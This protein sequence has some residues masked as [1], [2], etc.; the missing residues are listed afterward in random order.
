MKKVMI[1]D[2]NEDVLEMVSELVASNGYQPITASGGEDC[3]LKLEKERP[4]LILLDIN[5]PDIDGWSVLRKLKEMGLTDS[6]KVMMLT[7]TTDVG[8]DIFGLQDVV[9][10]YIRKPFSNRDLSERLGSALDDESMKVPEQQIVAVKEKK[11]GFLSRILGKSRNDELT[12][13]GKERVDASAMKYTVR[14]GFGYVVKEKKPTRSFEIFVDQVTHEIQGLCVTRQHPGTIRTKW[15]LEKTP[16]IWLSNKVGK[17]YVNPTN[18]GILSDTIVRFVEKSEESIILIDG[19]EFLIINNDFEK[20]LRMIHHIS[21]GVMEHKSRLLISIDP[22]ILEIRE[23]A[24]LERNMEIIDTQ[25][26]VA[27]MERPQEL[28]H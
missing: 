18:I 8:T 20:V 3:L 17:V 5:M 24:L 11:P 19:V 2:D 14:K 27:D 4:D 6:I 12:P 16:I 13:I 28:E 23:M 21:E 25:D 1:V 22:R 7:A 9:T 26:Y 15:G 10:G